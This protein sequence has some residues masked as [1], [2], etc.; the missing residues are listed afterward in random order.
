M[1]RRAAFIAVMA[2]LMPRSAVAQPAGST[3][4][5][6][7]G[8]M[9]VEPIHSGFLVA[10]DVKVTEVD[11]QTSELV[12]GYAGWLTDERIFIGGGGYWLANGNRNDREMAYGGLVVHWLVWNSGRVGV[13]AKGLV[14]GGEATLA[15]TISVR[16]PEV[17]T[18]G[19]VI[20]PATTVSQ[21]VRVRDAF[22]LAE[23]EAQLSFRLMK[24]LRLAVGAG[25]RFTGS[26]RR[27]GF[28]GDRL[29]GATGSLALQIG[30]GS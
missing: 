28:R 5:R 15:D 18:N 30:G 10:P 26:D 2:C 4:P 8:P 12:G 22:L 7:Q 16:V 23:P 6:T 11:R 9:I 19:R 24:Q 20:A 14:G 13:G 27:G 1:R 25:Y 29:D 17:R 3:A 21:R